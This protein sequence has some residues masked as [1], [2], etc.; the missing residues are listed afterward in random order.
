[1]KTNK[2]NDIDLD[3]WKDY[4]DVWTDSLWLID[5]RGEGG[6]P[7]YPGNFVPQIPEQLIKRYTKPGDW[8]IDPFC[9]SGTTAD[10][11]DRLQRNSLNVD[12]DA[13][14]IDQITPYF[15]RAN[16]KQVFY[17]GDS[18]NFNF[19]AALT[20]YDTDHA[21]LAILHPPYSSIIE[22][23]TKDADLSFS[24]TV[25]EFLYKLG[26][27]IGNVSQCLPPG[28][29]MALVMGDYYRAGQWE[30]LGF[31]C[32]RSILSCGFNLK[33]IVVKNF[34]DTFAKRN[35]EHLWRYRALQGGFY[36]FKHE[37]IFIFE[38]KYQSEQE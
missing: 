9:G 14:A 2:V 6:S 38:R 3:N 30:P 11:A 33:S 35:Q 19:L 4:D 24:L 16:A 21:T 20:H 18:Q 37:Y 13:D 26:R 31:R 27:V 10:V 36:I 15:P 28:S 5:K 23:S 34:T 7:N 17:Q 22:Y 29:I 32:M 25:K 12:L 1:M 8:V